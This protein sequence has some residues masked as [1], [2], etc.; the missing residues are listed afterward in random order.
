MELTVQRCSGISDVHFSL[1]YI[2]MKFICTAFSQLQYRPAKQN[3][4]TCKYL[5]LLDVGRQARS[6]LTLEIRILAEILN[7]ISFFCINECSKKI[8]SEIL[9]NT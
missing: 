9:F 3:L 8:N 5:I 4:K 6:S 2:S 1:L 7:T